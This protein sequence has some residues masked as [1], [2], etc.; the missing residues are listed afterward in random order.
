MKR[1]T[2]PQIMRTVREQAKEIHSLFLKC[3]H[4]NSA[5][6]RLLKLKTVSMMALSLLLG[7]MTLVG[8]A[9]GRTNA[10]I[11]TSA[12]TDLAGV[13][14]E[15]MVQAFEDQEGLKPIAGGSTVSGQPF[16]WVRFTVKNNGLE[17]A[18]KFTSKA[19]VYHNG[20]KITDPVAETMTL[21]AL[22]SRTLP[23]VRIN[24]AGRSGPISAVLVADLGNFVKETN[25]SNN[26]AETSFNVANK[27]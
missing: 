15:T 26:K 27:F 11:T 17:N 24:T 8:D 1:N 3:L 20:I 9:K 19:V 5:G 13:D 18:G 7:G 22:Q 25:E 16:I 14:L 2:D 12:G 21:N 4:A 23:M 6:V 10:P